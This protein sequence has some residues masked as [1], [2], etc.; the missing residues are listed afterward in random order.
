MIVDSIASQR[1][2]NHSSREAVARCPQCRRHFC[3]ECVTEHEEQVVCASCLKELLG[4]PSQRAR[5]LGIVTGL[6][7][8]VLGVLVAW[9][10]F[11]LLG[12][13]LL[14]LPTSFHEGSAWQV[15]GIE[16]K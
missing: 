8:C 12:R 4:Q 7:H 2:F 13:V 14:A 16:E 10:F 1:C 5:S 9:T 3:R 6:A 15:E 11:Y